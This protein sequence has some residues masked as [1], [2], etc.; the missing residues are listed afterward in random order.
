MVLGIAVVAP[1]LLIS[2]F[3]LSFGE[4]TRGSF[5]ER[6]IIKVY[7]SFTLDGRRPFGLFNHT[8]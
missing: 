5:L 3:K 6:D 2:A 4:F 7:D 1:C 8:S